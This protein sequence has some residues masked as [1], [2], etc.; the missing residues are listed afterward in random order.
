MLVIVECV[1]LGGEVSKV[2][3]E[4]LSVRIDRAGACLHRSNFDVIA[5]SSALLMVCLSGC[6]LISM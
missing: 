6:D 1:W 2:V 3:Y 4:A 5:A